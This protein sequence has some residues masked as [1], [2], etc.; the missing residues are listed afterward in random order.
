[1]SL[2]HYVKRTIEENLWE[3]FVISSLIF[4]LII[5]FINRNSNGTWSETY[6]Y[7]GNGQKLPLYFDKN[8]S[9]GELLVRNMLQ[10][11]TKMEW[12][13]IRPDFL[14]NKVTGQNLEFDCFNGEYGVAIEVQGDQH[15]RYIPYFHK[16]YQDFLNQ[17]Y[18][19]ELKRMMARDNNILLIEVPYSITKK[20]GDCLEKFL[21]KELNRCG[22]YV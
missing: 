13:K 7:H 12:G 2:F 6:I 16:N 21:K 3:V 11:M 9:K 15:Y 5:G 8:D 4:L 20:K 19:D 17:Q 10:D 18:R 22:I 1:M 14:K